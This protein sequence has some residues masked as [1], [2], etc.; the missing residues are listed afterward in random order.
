MA[1]KINTTTKNFL[2]TLRLTKQ[3]GC[4]SKQQFKTFREQAL[5]GSPE[6]AKQSLYK[7][8]KKQVVQQINDYEKE[9]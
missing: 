6:E 7:L 4:I 2:K 8:L 3:W 1:N 5:N 9:E